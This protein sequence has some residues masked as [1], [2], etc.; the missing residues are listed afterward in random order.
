[1]E[2]A[3]VAKI[4]LS[5]SHRPR[6][7]ESFSLDN[8]SLNVVSCKVLEVEYI[9]FP[10]LL[11]SHFHNLCH[12]QVTPYTI[13]A[14][15]STIQLTQHSGLPDPVLF[16]LTSCHSLSNLKLTAQHASRSKVWSKSLGAARPK[17]SHCLG[18]TEPPD[19][20]SS[21][22]NKARGITSGFS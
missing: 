7:M 6:T 17:P 9:S 19:E 13:L 10:V 16:D 12:T 14:F 18:F 20:E 5:T 3:L 8:H 21:R 22:N 1:M 11:Y 4:V 15:T 2:C